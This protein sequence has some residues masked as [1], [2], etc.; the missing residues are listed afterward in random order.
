MWL[1]GFEASKMFYSIEER[2]IQS[3]KGIDE[4]WGIKKVDLLAELGESNEHI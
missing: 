4:I 1:R 2:I 3:C